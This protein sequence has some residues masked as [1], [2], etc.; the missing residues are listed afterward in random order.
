MSRVQIHAQVRQFGCNLVEITGGEPLIQEGTPALITDLLDAGCEV[1][2]ETNGSVDIDRADRRSSRIMDVKCPSSG[3]SNH[4]DAAN[5]E[6]LT[7]NDQVK[8]VIGDHGDFLFARNLIP[9]LP[10]CVPPQRIL[11]SAVAGRLPAQRL[12][13]WILE[14]R[15]S[16]RFQLQLHKVIWPDR[17]RGV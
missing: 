2:V 3:E 7:A 13:G 9:R 10:A 11:F 5:L 16:V 6:R 15:L 12:A 4:N 8:F 1:L 17:D 14:A